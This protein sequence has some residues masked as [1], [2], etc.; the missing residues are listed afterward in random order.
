MKA[1]E[2]RVG[3]YVYDTIAN[4]VVEVVL[5]RSIHRD[6]R[7]ITLPSRWNCRI[8][9]FNPI[10]LTEEWLLKLGFNFDDD[11][12]WITDFITGFYMFE[13]AELSENGY[14]LRVNDEYN[15]GCKIK[16]VHQLQNLYFVLTGEELK[17]K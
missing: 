6:D 3:N 9:E 1:Q 17:T 10:S 11:C 12:G 16:F 5:I 2:L 8:E 7:I 13:L 14:E 15:T 4:A